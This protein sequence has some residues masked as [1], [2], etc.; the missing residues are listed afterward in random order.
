MRKSLATLGAVLC[1]VATGGLADALPASASA[2]PAVG[3]SAAGPS[4]G[5]AVPALGIDNPMEGNLGFGTIVE[6]DAL[7]GGTETEGTVAIGG[8]LTFGPGYSVMT[9]PT[10]TYRA[11]G[12]SEPTALLVGGRILMSDSAPDGVL[13]VENN[14]YVHVQDATGIKALGA[15]GNAASLNTEVVESAAAYGSTARVQLTTRESP[16]RLGLPAS[17]ID[18]GVLFTAYRQRALDIAACSDDV[19]LTNAAGMPL[20]QQTGFAP[21][22][23]AYVTLTPH[24]TN[25]L[26]LTGQDVDDLAGLTFRTAPSA[27]T[28]FVVVVDPAAG[29]YSW[30]IPNLAGVSGAQAPYMLWDFP[31]ATDITLAAGGSPV[32]TIFAPNAHLTDLD[33]AGIEGDIAVR[34][35]W[36]GPPGAGGRYT[37][38]G[39]I[40][41]FPFAAQ[42]DCVPRATQ[43]AATGSTSPFQPRSALPS[44]AASPSEWTGTPAPSSSSRGGGGA[45]R[46]DDGRGGGHHLAQTGIGQG[47]LAVLGMAAV[48]GPCCS[49]CSGGAGAAP[50]PATAVSDTTAPA[51]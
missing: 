16:S 36:A 33:P 32:G 28:P 38:A 46:G 49:A 20:A 3:P 8:N 34:S 45:G 23:S 42:L 48:A 11:P 21:G 44:R 40:H 2:G 12:E 50:D 17:P 6:Q 47:R 35:F 25:V 4:A 22:T 14:G 29:A 51:L 13:R 26:H 15:G 19:A 30:H 37:D 18:F 10:G 24:R 31:A 5:P 41:D 43:A 39:Q 7:L 9:H 1:C 27:G